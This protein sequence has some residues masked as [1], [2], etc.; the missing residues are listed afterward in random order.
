MV[1]LRRFPGSI[2][3]QKPQTRTERASQTSIRGSSFRDTGQRQCRSMKAGGVES[4]LVSMSS[5]PDALVELD[6]KTRKNASNISNL[7]PK[8]TQML[9]KRNRQCET[10]H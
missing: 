3:S 7:Q 4:L 8:I 1:H 5:V 10:H 6:E 2:L 9:P